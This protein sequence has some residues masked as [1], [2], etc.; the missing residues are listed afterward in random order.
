MSVLSSADRQR[1]R[2]AVANRIPAAE[3]GILEKVSRV[4]AT[5]AAQDRAPAA[6]EV[7]PFSPRGQ[8]VEEICEALLEY[9]CEITGSNASFLTDAEGLPIA[10]RGEVGVNVELAASLLQWLKLYTEIAGLPARQVRVA[11]D[12][13]MVDLYL[14]RFFGSTRALGL[15]ILKQGGFPAESESWIYQALLKTEELLSNG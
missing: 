11:G 12:P 6:K 9:V 1:L 7:K 3:R 8:G 5:I 15:G 10:V 14:F 4:A 13:P 2:Q